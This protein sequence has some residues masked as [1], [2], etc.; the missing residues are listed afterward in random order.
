MENNSYPK[1]N[2]L[3]TQI[4]LSRFRSLTG[5]EKQNKEIESAHSTYFKD[6]MKKAAELDK[7]KK[8][9]EN[10]NATISHVYKLF[11]ELLKE[12]PKVNL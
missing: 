10:A 7:K 2:L 1:K 5:N 11:E 8:V 12:T 9:S 3:S 6:A 4:D